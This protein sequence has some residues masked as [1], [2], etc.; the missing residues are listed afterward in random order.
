M[1]IP[2]IFIIIGL[3]FIIP[4]EKRI[5][6]LKHLSK[7]GTLYK[8]LPYQII[9]SNVS[10]NGRQLPKIEVKFQLPSGEIRTYEGSPRIDFKTQDEDGYVDLL[11]DMENPDNYYVDFNIE[12]I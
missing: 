5:K 9:G 1:I 3:C 7:Y 10:V 2:A 11:L 6:K 12:Q 8:N 4:T